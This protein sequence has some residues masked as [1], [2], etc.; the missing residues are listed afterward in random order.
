MKKAIQI[1]PSNQSFKISELDEEISLS[2]RRLKNE[3]IGKARFL[4][5]DNKSN[6]RYNDKS[7]VEL[8]QATYE[9]LERLIEKTV[10]ASS[11]RELGKY[12]LNHAEETKSWMQREIR[13]V[14]LKILDKETELLSIQL[15]YPWNEKLKRELLLGAIIIVEAVLSYK[16]FQLFGDSSLITFVIT[17]SLAATF[18]AASHHLVPRAI[19]LGKSRRAKILIG[20]VILIVA[21]AF[22]YGLGILRS[23]Y[24]K[25]V[26]GINIHPALF[27]FLNLVLF[28]VASAISLF[29]LPTEK[30]IID[31]EHKDRIEKDLENLYKQKDK[32]DEESKLLSKNLTGTL[33]ERVAK[34]A[35]EL[36]MKQWVNTLCE[37]TKAAYI[38]EF[39]LARDNNSPV[40]SSLKN[41]F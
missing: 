30:Q 40:S 15:D 2:H 28:I 33:Q 13:G 37:E 35:Y 38:L 24:F 21:V 25:E 41:L 31:K 23:V 27:A 17:L 26:E 20:L 12:D 16:A 39:E 7:H 29:K 9:H 1:Q 22:F 5:R 3:Y 4:A 36:S 11:Q 8:I 18:W 34:M 6:L 14:E 32:L 10:Q 19:N